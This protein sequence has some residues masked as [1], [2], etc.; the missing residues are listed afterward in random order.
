M[1]QIQS[2]P[3]FS[4]YHFRILSFSLFA[5][6]ALIDQFTNVNKFMDAS[7]WT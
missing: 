5:F 6:H 4:F 3:L 2:L 7:L 1:N